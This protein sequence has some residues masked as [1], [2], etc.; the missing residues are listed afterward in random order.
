M[1]DE[2]EIKAKAKEIYAS[3]TKQEVAGIMFAV[4]MMLGFVLGP[5]ISAV[6]GIYLR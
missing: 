4:W 5:T 3:K 2:K 6:L 1:S